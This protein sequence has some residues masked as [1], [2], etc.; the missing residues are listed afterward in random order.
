MVFNPPHTWFRRKRI[1]WGWSP[2]TWEGWAIVVLP[3][4]AVWA[5]KPL[6]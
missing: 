6:Y 2:G 5:A 1:G 3:L 4:V